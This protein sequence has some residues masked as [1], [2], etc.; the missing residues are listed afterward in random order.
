MHHQPRRFVQD[1]QGGVLIKNV[2]RD[3]LRQQPGRGGFGNFD[4]D[5]L[6][7]SGA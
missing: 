5:T 4:L 2:Q 1:Q 6:T 3:R 7:G